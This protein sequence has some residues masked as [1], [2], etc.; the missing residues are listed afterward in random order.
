MIKAFKGVYGLI[1]P[2]TLKQYNNKY[3]AILAASLLTFLAVTFVITCLLMV[4][5]S[6]KSPDYVRNPHKY[7]KTIKERLFFNTTYYNEK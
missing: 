7:K 6:S 4:K 3:C 1:L 5:G 2:L